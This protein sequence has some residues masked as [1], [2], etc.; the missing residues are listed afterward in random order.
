MSYYDILLAKKLSGGGGGGIT[1]ESL[2]V[3]SN[4]TYTAETGKAYTPV[5]VAVPNTY[6]ASDEG[7]VVSSGAL[8]AQTSAT[9]ESNDTYDTT[10]INSVTVN[11]SGGGG[12]PANIVTGTF[13]GTTAGNMEIEV[14]Y[15]G[16]G[17]PIAFTVIPKG[18]AKAD[19]GSQTSN[20]QA[21]TG[22]KLNV[23]DPS[24]TG[25]AKYYAG[26]YISN[27]YGSLEHYSFNNTA[28][29]YMNGTTYGVGFKDA[30]HFT[31]S[32]KN[33]TGQGFVIGKEFCYSIIYY[34][35]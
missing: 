17:Y 30:T 31:V 27:N 34:A 11:V 16:T 4:G 2:S 32:I 29:G 22:Y 8:V 20:I 6:T 28:L 7:K 21:I 5:T 1:V 12:G 26:V 18:G 9:Y 14:P 10:L 3:N 25:T 33:G 15:S 24:G 19:I 13:T 23:G 35:A